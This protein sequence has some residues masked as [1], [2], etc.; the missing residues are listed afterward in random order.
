MSLSP[1]RLSGVALTGANLAPAPDRDDG[2]LT[3]LIVRKKSCISV[4]FHHQA[5]APRIFFQATSPASSSCSP[6]PWALFLTR[7]FDSLSPS[8]AWCATLVTF[9][10]SESP[11]SFASTSPG[12][13]DPFNRRY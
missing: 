2:I 7:S 8:S 3:K 11:A 10:E 1:G 4:G 6:S 5:V 13:Q 9:S 12:E